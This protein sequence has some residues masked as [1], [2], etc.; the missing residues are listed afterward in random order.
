MKNPKISA[1]DWY[2]TSCCWAFIG[3]KE[4]A[5]DAY[6]KALMASNGCPSLISDKGTF[7]GSLFV[8]M[9]TLRRALNK[10]N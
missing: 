10:C 3:R 9:A 7:D 4:E 6:A 2:N 1:T 8:R 5:E